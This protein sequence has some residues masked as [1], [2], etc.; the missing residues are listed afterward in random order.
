MEITAPTIAFGANSCAKSATGRTMR[1]ATSRPR[2]PVVFVR[3]IMQAYERRGMDP[4]AALRQAG[5][6]PGELLDPQGR[7][8]IELFEALSSH[9]MRE[10]DDEALGWFSR[11]LPWGSYGMLLRASLT[12][13]TLD[14][15]LRRW[16]R[17]HGLLTEDVRIELRV[18]SATGV[19]RVS[20]LVDL[21]ALREFCL[22]SLL[23]NLHGVACWLADSRIALN[24]ARFPFAAP[25]HAEAYGRMFGSEIAFDAHEAELSFDA[26]YLQLPVVRD[27]VSLRRML[28][29]PISL[30]ARQYRQDRL[31]SRR[32]NSFIAARAGSPLD[33][34]MIA[35]HLNISVRS[36]QRHL[37]DEDTSVL[38][39]TT[40]ARRLRAEELLRRSDL[41]LKR[42][43][44]L[45]GYGD[46][47]S[48]GR[49]FRHWTGQTPA[50]FRRNA[51]PP[52]KVL[53]S[54]LGESQQRNG[55]ASG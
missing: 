17:H 50:E 13:P 49:A 51:S 5:L 38:A 22:V 43:A 2:T 21:G 42:V 54:D 14:V 15:A 52:A 35:G 26:I 11:R 27:D 46:E 19:V 44:R 39:L 4:G 40:R 30:M 1:K 9:A 31:L 48:F 29:E 36:L 6:A 28:R 53:P 32:I 41:P 12:A 8:A 16:C 7:V 25:A 23:R 24:G 3:A 20:E 33:A 18:E 45:A 34:E 55:G 37:H 47:S 10:L